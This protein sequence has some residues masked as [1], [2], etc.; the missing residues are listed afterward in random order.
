MLGIGLGFGLGLGPRLRLGFVVGWVCAQ[1]AT[2]LIVSPDRQN[3]CAHQ[4]L[5]EQGGPVVGRWAMASCLQEVIC[6]TAAQ[7]LTYHSTQ[8]ESRAQAKLVDPT[9]GRGE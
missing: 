2:W 1:G 9:E 5:P 4:A 6:S 3:A 7:L 8:T